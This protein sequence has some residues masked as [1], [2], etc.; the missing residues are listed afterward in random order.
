MLLE[1]TPLSVLEVQGTVYYAETFRLVTNENEKS[2]EFAFD[3]KTKHIYLALNPGS[4]INGFTS[5]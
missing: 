5:E 2:F 3:L 4:N 1:Q